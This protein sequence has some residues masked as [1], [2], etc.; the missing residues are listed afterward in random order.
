MIEQ[1]ATKAPSPQPS[2][3]VPGEG[4]RGVPGE[5]ERGAIATVALTK[6]YGSLTALDHLDLRLEKGDVFGFIGPNGAGKST[7][8]KILAGLLRRTSGTAYVLGS[9]VASNG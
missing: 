6:C 3:G 7:T 4:E 1:D 2:P 9:E 5:G 8:M